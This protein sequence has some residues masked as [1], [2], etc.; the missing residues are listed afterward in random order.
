VCP[1]FGRKENTDSSTVG[2]LISLA[3]V[4]HGDFCPGSLRLLLSFLLFFFLK[5]VFNITSLST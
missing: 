2:L 3:G 1:F 5:I 4:H